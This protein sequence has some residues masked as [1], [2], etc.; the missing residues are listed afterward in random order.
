MKFIEIS[1][2][3]KVHPGEYILHVPTKQVVLCGSFNRQN[4]C[5]RV[6]G[7]G[8]MF[9]DKIENFQKIKLARS[10]RK[11]INKAKGCGGC[12]KKRNNAEK[13]S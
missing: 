9:T 13:S 10:E 11:E 7:S 5:I 12:K 2:D 3:I 4:D 8:R 6:L 1:E